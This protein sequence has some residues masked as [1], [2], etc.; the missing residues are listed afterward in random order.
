MKFS[1]P[2]FFALLVLTAVLGSFSS[3]NSSGQPSF[4]KAVAYGL[5][6]GDV[7]LTLCAILS[8]GLLA[9]LLLAIITGAFTRK[10]W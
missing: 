2:L 4:A 9:W 3:V 5:H 6:H 10:E 7:L 8:V 1:W